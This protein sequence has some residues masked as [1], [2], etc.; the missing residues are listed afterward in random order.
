MES[1]GAA[2]ADQIMMF[3]KKPG[4]RLP[5]I[6]EMPRN[7]GKFSADFHKFSWGVPAFGGESQ[8]EF[9]LINCGNWICTWALPGN[10]LIQ[11]IIDGEDPDYLD[12][13]VPLISHFHVKPT[14]T[15]F[16]AGISQVC[17][18]IY[19]FYY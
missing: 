15:K 9:L 2:N 11:K 5:F 6:F 7:S 17:N 10:E 19:K 12:C 8:T 3:S 16:K 13:Q 14:L 4:E 18:S 1:N